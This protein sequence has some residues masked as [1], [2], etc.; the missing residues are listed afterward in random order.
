[1]VDAATHGSRDSPAP[2]LASVAACAASF[3]RQVRAVDGFMVVPKRQA[4]GHPIGRL[5]VV[6]GWK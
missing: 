1:M 3:L 4:E 6:F 2:Q 5:G